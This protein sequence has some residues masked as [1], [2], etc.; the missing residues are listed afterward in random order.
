MKPSSWFFEIH[1][2]PA[3]FEFENENSILH[4]GSINITV[5]H[6]TVYHESYYPVF[7]E[8]FYTFKDRKGGALNTR[9]TLL[10]QFTNTI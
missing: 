1:K 5:V 3:K 4:G 9:R 10:C 6:V 2:F 8:N 7:T